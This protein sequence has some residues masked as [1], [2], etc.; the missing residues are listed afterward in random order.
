MNWMLRNL[1]PHVWRDGNA[2]ASSNFNPVTSSRTGSQWGIHPNTMSTKPILSPPK[3]SLPLTSSSK[4]FNAS[5]DA[6]TAFSCSFASVRKAVHMLNPHCIQTN[7]SMKNILMNQVKTISSY[8][9]LCFNQCQNN[10]RV[11]WV[12][13]ITKCPIYGL[14]LP[15][16]F[17]LKFFFF[18]TWI[19]EKKKYHVKDIVLNCCYL[20]IC[21]FSPI[22]CLSSLKGILR[23]KGIFLPCLLNVF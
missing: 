4:A 22:S 5:N 6:S 10:K 7:S 2:S 13:F 20:F 9:L 16:W 8:S 23:Q 18:W 3:N 15:C 19:H 1:W 17:C 12:T 11:I 21:K 14:K